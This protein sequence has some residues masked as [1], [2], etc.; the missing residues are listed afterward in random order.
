MRAVI[1]DLGRVLIDYN[2]DASLDAVAALS[3][4]T[5]VEIRALFQAIAGATG[6]GELDAEQIHR[7]FV[8]Q[9]GVPDDFGRFIE[10]FGAG[11]TR[12]EAAL[13]YAVELQQ[14][15]GVT[16]GV[17]SNTNQAHILWLDAHLPELA[18]LDLVMMSSEVGMAKP[19]PAIYELALELLNL[20]AGQAIFVDD[21]TPNVIAAQG[22]GMAGIVHTSWETTR[23]ALEAWLVQP[24]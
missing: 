10:A 12:N 18:Q 24:V 2:H 17:I 14:R 1:F 20:P 4:V 16:V 19:D 22:L 3:Q 15:P 8:E 23:P 21:L 9:A 11:L 6:I 7:Y 13:S 5:P